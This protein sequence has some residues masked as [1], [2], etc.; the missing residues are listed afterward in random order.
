M[1][2]YRTT[3]SSE[4]KT[5]VDL[6]ASS[7][8]KATVEERVKVIEGPI[9]KEEVKRGH[10]R[11]LKAKTKEQL[12]DLF[13]CLYQWQVPMGISEMLRNKENPF[14]TSTFYTVMD[15]LMERQKAINDESRLLIKEVDCDGERIP[16]KY[17]LTDYGRRV[18]LRILSSEQYSKNSR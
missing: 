12:P 5:A 7:S 2:Q 10:L 13:R 11:T 1:A 8:H 14:K 9:I 6:A 18:T 4:T 3:V 15:R 16:K 17:V